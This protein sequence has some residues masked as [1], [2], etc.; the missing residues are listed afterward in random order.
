VSIR[1]I[2]FDLGNTLLEYSL[3]GHWRE[4]LLQRVAEMYP[5][6]CELAKPVAVSQ[7]DFTTRINEVIG[8]R[9]RGV[10]GD[11]FSDYVPPVV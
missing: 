1:A 6:V 2:L 10:E 8:N 4:F 9:A 7:A 5:L 11:G 3:Q